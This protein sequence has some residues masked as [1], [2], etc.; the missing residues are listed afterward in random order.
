ML[1]DAVQNYG[2]APKLASLAHPTCR[3]ALLAIGTILLLL[4]RRRPSIITKTPTTYPT[5]IEYTTSSSS[6]HAFLTH[7]RCPCKNSKRF[8]NILALSAQ[9]FLIPATFFYQNQCYR[10]ALMTFTLALTSLIY[11][12]TH[13][14]IARAV[15]VATIWSFAVIVTCH[16]IILLIERPRWFLVLSL[17][18]LIV[19]N[20]INCAPIF[21]ERRD[22]STLSLM[23][24]FTMHQVTTLLLV[25]LAIGLGE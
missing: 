25:F 23:A 3:D 10:M 15:D 22:P 9:T 8:R 14:P 20:V 7:V 24:H 5:K 12:T 1:L 21:R 17:A 2:L 4:L 16:V 13:N 11:H 19:V 6:L 18:L